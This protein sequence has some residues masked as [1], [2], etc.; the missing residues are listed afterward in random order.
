IMSASTEYS[1]AQLLDLFSIFSA[2][3]DKLT[4]VVI[5]LAT[6][7]ASTGLPLITDAVTLKDRVGLAQLTSGKL[8]L[9]SFFMVP[10]PC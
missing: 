6:S 4:M 8:Q 7:I 10:A 3:P 9:F 1:N 5:A 2:N